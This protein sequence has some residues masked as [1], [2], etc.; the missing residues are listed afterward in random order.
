MLILFLNTSTVWKWALLLKFWRNMVP[1]SSG[2]KYVG[3]EYSQVIYIGRFGPARFMCER[4]SWCNKKGC[5]VSIHVASIVLSRNRHWL[6]SFYVSLWGPHHTLY[7]HLT[8]LDPEDGGSIF[9]KNIGSTVYFCTVPVPTNKI[10][11]NWRLWNIN[12]NSIFHSCSS[13][14]L[15]LSPFVVYEAVIFLNVVMF[16][17]KP[18]SLKMINCWKIID[19]NIVNSWLSHFFIHSSYLP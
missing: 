9:L 2:I 4:K 6:L 3:W 8:H 7:S 11:K 10:N 5:F 15:V 16:L 14:G 19:Y 1:P 18:Y 13:K 12:I 17:K